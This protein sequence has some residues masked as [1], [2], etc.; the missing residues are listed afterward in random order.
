MLFA[1]CAQHGV[2]PVQWKSSTAME[3]HKNKG[4]TQQ[5]SQYLCIQISSVVA[6]LYR[7][8]LRT[9]VLQY[10][11]SHFEDGQM[12]SLSGRGIGLATSLLAMYQQLAEAAG[13][14]CC[15]IF[16][17]VASA[18]DS[19]ARS[20]FTEGA[21]F[22]LEQAGLPM[23][24]AKCV[25]ETLRSTLISTGGVGNI[26]TTSRGTRAGSTMGDLTYTDL[27]ATITKRMKVA[28]LER[29]IAFL[30]VVVVAA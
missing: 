23:H 27:M 30:S 22:M 16:I 8:T 7:R 13:T 20:F 21:P 9:R 25:S 3:L 5:L 11:W 17:D 12:G 24:I 6:N 15:F 14:N 26:C 4:S 10:C 2:E 1:K 19:A 18:F 28:L 29:D